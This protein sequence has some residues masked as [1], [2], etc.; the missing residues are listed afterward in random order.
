VVEVLPLVPVMPIHC[1]GLPVVLL[2]TRS[3]QASSTSLMTGMLRFCA[4]RMNGVRGLKTGEVITMSVLSQS[5]WSKECRSA[6]GFFSSTP[7][8]LPAREPSTSIMLCPETPRPATITV[9]PSIF[10][11]I[12]LQSETSFAVIAHSYCGRKAAPAIVS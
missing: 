6:S 1:A 5:I 9:L 2:F 8:T 4:S 3:C 11:S 12:T 7:S 10:I